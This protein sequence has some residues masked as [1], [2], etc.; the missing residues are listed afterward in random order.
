MVMPHADSEKKTD[1]KD[2][3]LKTAYIFFPQWGALFFVIG[4]AILIPIGLFVWFLLDLSAASDRVFAVEALI[5]GLL[6]EQV[7]RRLFRR[8]L[9]FS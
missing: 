4:G 8:K 6:A 2:E 5:S 1:A 9:M 7:F 3:E